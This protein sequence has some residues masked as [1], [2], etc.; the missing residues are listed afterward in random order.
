M[1]VLGGA[2]WGC[3]RLATASIVVPAAPGTVELQSTRP[4]DPARPMQ[5]A[6]NAFRTGS[7]H[8]ALCTALKSAPRTGSTGRIDVLIQKARPENESNP[9]LLTTP[10]FGSIPK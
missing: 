1:N 2:D 5:N 9:T 4:M 10:Y 8:G 6:K 7:L 3:S